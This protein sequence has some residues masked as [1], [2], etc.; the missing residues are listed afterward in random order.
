M[1]DIFGHVA[2]G[3]NFA[4]FSSSVSPGSASHTKDD[5]PT[6]KTQ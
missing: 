4:A 2:L 3:V 5:A 6:S 1:E